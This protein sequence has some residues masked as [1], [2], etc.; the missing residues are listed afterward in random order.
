ML[1]LVLHM[2]VDR[3]RT[4]VRICQATGSVPTSV[5]QVRWRAGTRQFSPNFKEGNAPSGR[6]NL[7]AVLAP[8]AIRRRQTKVV[9][10]DRAR[11]VGRTYH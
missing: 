2:S 1:M 4:L 8:T 6:H 5:I 3:N 11:A 9:R 10:L 7:N